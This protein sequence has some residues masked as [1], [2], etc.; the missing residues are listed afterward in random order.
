[1]KSSL[2]NDNELY[3]S[4]TERMYWEAFDR[5]KS[6]SPIRLPAGSEVTQNNVAREAGNDPSA[7]KKKRYARLV[8]SIQQWLKDHPSEVART[9]ERLSRANAKIDA[10]NRKIE[11]LTRQRDAALSQL[12]SA[13]S[14]LVSLLSERDAANT[15]DDNVIELN[16]DNRT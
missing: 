3:V 6:S 15:I 9:N 2:D 14:Q 1:M 8:A 11:L 12:L 7:L 5:L 4:T 10:L 13:E 16:P